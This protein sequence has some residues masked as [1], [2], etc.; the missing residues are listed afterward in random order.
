MVALGDF[1]KALHLGPR[2]FGYVYPGMLHSMGLGQRELNR[3]VEVA[4][5]LKRFRMDLIREI[6]A[7][8]RPKSGQYQKML[9]AILKALDH[10]MM[11]ADRLIFSLVHDWQDK[12]AFRSRV[13]HGAPLVRVSDEFSD[14][15]D[16]FSCWE[17]GYE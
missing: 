1:T 15:D 6:A 5:K 14:S 10:Q 9:R 4:N 16:I 7:S 13:Y 17:Q 12:R 2:H 8:G 3:R 11:E